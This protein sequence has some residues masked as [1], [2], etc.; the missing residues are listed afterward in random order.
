MTP[1][2][3]IYTNAIT[4]L[5]AP[6]LTIDCDV[7]VNGALLADTIRS[8]G[9]SEL[10]LDDNVKI[11]QNLVCDGSIKLGTTSTV[12]KLVISGGVQNVANE[13][14]ALR[15][16]G[17]NNNIKI[18]LQNA[19]TTT[20][21]I[22]ELRSTSTGGFDITDR[23]GGATR[24]SIDTNGNH[25]FSGASLKFGTTDILKKFQYS[26]RVKTDGTIRYT[27]GVSSFTSSRTAL[28]TYL[29]ALGSGPGVQYPVITAC[30]HGSGIVCCSGTGS[31]NINFA[32]YELNGT[33]ADKEFS[34]TSS[35]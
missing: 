23:L 22:Y 18:E 30:I 33:A 32:T 29:I 16:I 14:T 15:V 1:N 3:V 5:E 28:G 34:L 7:A 9:A 11:N 26:G 10:T 2:R 4:N 24:Y 17:S 35:I 12:A 31:N 6:E 21:K 25:T 19:T 20:G 27:N 8:S 13:E